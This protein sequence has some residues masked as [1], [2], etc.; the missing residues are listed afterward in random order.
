MFIFVEFFFYFS[1]LHLNCSGLAIIIIFNLLSMMLARPHDLGGEFDMLVELN[2]D[3]LLCHFLFL[4]L[5]FSFNI[6]LSWN[7]A[8]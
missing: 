8:M 5:F 4:F 1:F 2:Q 7:L 3:A 6:G